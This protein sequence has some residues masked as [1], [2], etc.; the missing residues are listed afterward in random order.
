MHWPYPLHQKTS[1]YSKVDH[2]KYIVK[3]AKLFSRIEWFKNQN[4]SFGKVFSVPFTEILTVRSVGF[5]F[6]I[7]DFDDLMNNQT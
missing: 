1:E 6:N 2:E 5:T 3:E 4:A 7:L